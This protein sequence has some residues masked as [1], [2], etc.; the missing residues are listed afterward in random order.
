ML[1][2]I[3]YAILFTLLYLAYRGI[4][5]KIYTY[6]DLGPLGEIKERYLFLTCLYVF[7]FITTWR[8][9]VLSPSGIG[10]SYRGSET[11]L[12]PF[13]EIIETNRLN[14]FYEFV[15]GDERM[16]LS[17]LIMEYLLTFAQSMIIL[18]PLSLSIFAAY[19]NNVKRSV[20][21]LV[22]VMVSYYFSGELFVGST[23]IKVI[24]L[25]G[26]TYLIY[27]LIEKMFARRKIIIWLS[28]FILLI[29]VVF[30]SD[31]HIVS[32]SYASSYKAPETIEFEEPYSS[33]GDVDL[34]F[35]SARLR[36]D[37]TEIELDYTLNNVPELDIPYEY[38]LLNMTLDLKT[39]DEKYKYG[40]SSNSS[41][42]INNIDITTSYRNKSVFPLTVYGISEI[43]YVI[44]DPDLM[45]QISFEDSGW[46]NDEPYTCYRL[47]Y[48][49]P[50]VPG[51]EL[52]WNVPLKYNDLLDRAY[53]PNVSYY[54]KKR[55]LEETETSILYE[56]KNYFYD[57]ETTEIE[58][59]GPEIINAIY[60]RE[61]E[62]DINNPIL[63]FD[64]G[65]YNEW[66]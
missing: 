57:R 62:I 18:L 53:N 42:R 4:K 30:T 24:L 60:S 58:I 35:H 21:L 45:E 65:D 46:L 56:V 17:R 51:Y 52:R 3:I 29:G 15:S 11:Y 9:T 20:W 31:I 37:H 36:E 54:T 22:T 63:H 13:S 33:H 38:K 1:E 26:F 2:T 14:I 44:I 34:I 47:T 10:V 25:Y 8:F 59:L 50:K 64:N 27:W 61:F 12:V 41:L 23:I 48:R 7:I 19:K 40:F 5:Q 39:G 55:I 28:I 49:V 66:R 16:S 6:K 32:D 43:M